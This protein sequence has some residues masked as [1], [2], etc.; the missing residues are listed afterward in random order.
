MNRT[1]WICAVVAAFGL[2]SYVTVQVNRTPR[3]AATPELRAELTAILT[4]N[5]LLPVPMDDPPGKIIDAAI[6]FKMPTCS[7][8]GFLLPLPDTLLADVQAIRFSEITGAKYRSQAFRD[9]SGGSVLHAR[10]TRAIASLKSAFG[11]AAGRNGHTVLAF[12]TPIDCDK[13]TPDL[14]RFW[15]PAA[16]DARQD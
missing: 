10:A 12:F 9:A 14:S 11:L 13:P 4:S 5:G 16:S 7:A 15:A 6:R 3:F 1:A 2:A 8:D